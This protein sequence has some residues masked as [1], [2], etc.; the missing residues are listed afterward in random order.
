MIQR[1]VE[2]STPIKK[3]SKPKKTVIPF[4]VLRCLNSPCAHHLII[5]ESYKVKADDKAPDGVATYHLAQDKKWY[6]IGYFQ[7]GCFDTTPIKKWVAK[8]KGAK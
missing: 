1:S 6:L 3:S 5:G 4:F 2:P 7:L 8:I